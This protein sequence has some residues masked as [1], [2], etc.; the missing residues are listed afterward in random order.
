MKKVFLIIAFLLVSVACFWAGVQY[1]RLKKSS[2]NSEVA[3]LEEPSFNPYASYEEEI[4]G[5]WTP[6][7]MA[8]GTLTFQYGVCSH[9]TKS[10]GGYVDREYPF[11]VEGNHLYLKN[12]YWGVHPEFTLDCVIRIWEENGIQYLEVQNVAGFSG[13]YKKTKKN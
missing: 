8:V 12:Q 5:N 4:I 13:K 1:E 11:T 3:E 9:H 10:Y 7:E 6:V 2:E